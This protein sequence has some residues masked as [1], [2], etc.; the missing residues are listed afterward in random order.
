MTMVE[1]SE[2]KKKVERNNE[3][4]KEAELEMKHILSELKSDYGIESIDD[5]DAYLEDLEKQKKKLDK[6]IAKLGAEI[7]SVLS[8]V[9]DD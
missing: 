1:F 3:R 4:A 2:L 5:V 9:S 6:E 8:G 7:E